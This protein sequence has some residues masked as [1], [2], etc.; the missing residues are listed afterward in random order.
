MTLRKKKIKK[1][2]NCIVHYGINGSDC[3][4]SQSIQNIDF[5]DTVRKRNK[6]TTHFYRFYDNFVSVKIILQF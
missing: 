3:V 1:N 4:Y 2:K 5:M 6:N